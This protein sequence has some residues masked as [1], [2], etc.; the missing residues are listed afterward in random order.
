[1]PPLAGLPLLTEIRCCSLTCFLLFDGLHTTPISRIRQTAELY[2]CHLDY[3]NY[4]GD[5][6]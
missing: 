6:I 4:F 1:M 5:K 3:M 2:D